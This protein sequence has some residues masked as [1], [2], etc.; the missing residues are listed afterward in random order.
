M[1]FKGLAHVGVV[2]LDSKASIDFYTKNLGFT[3]KSQKDMGDL[4]I[5]FIELGDLTI[6]LLENKDPSGI[7]KVHGLINH[8]AIEVEGIEEIVEGLKKKNIDFESQNV[9][10]VPDLLG[11]IK[12]IFLYGPSG[13]RIELFE[14]IK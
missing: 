3:Y 9:G 8:L 14:Y 10:V 5:S 11:G 2:A 7:N 6:E 4:K 12:A 1:K 13:E